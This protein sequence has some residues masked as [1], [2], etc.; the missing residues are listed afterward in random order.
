MRGKGKIM[1]ST[2]LAVLV[3]GLLLLLAGCARMR[4]AP[5]AGDPIIR[6]GILEDQDAIYFEPQSEFSIAAYDEKE[7]F[8]ALEKGLWKVTIQSLNP[9]AA[10]FRILLY[11]SQESKRA[12]EYAQRMRGK[13]LIVMVKSQGEQLQAGSKNLIDHTYYRVILDKEFSSSA[14]ADLF[15]KSKTALQQGRV[16]RDT[17]KAIMGKIALQTPKG[18]TILITQALRITGT[19]I[20]LRDVAVGSGYHWARN[21]TRTYGGEMELRI[22]SKGKLTAINVVPLELYL[23]GVVAGEMAKSFPDEAL[24]AQAII[25]RTL[26]LNTF[27]RFHRDSEF[28]VC[29]DVH[30]QAYIGLIHDS[31]SVEKAVHDTKGL[32]L[33]Y[34]DAL[35]TASYSAVCGGH[36]SDAAEVWDSDGE[37]YLR[38]LLDT[39]RNFGEFDLSKEENAAIWV[40]SEPDVCCNLK[41]AGNPDFGKYAEKYFRWE[42]RVPRAE[43][44]KLIAEQ[45]GTSIGE[46]IDIV[47]LKR[48]TSGRLASINIVGTEESV[49]VRKE[50]NIRRA[51]SKSTLYSACFTIAKEGV[52]NGLAETFVFKGAGWG[53]G[54]GLCQLGAAVRAQKGDT[55]SEILAY[56]YPG[57][58]IKQLY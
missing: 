54:V 27:G 15:I 19:T 10:L 34:N 11:E 4:Y 48:G 17:E 50:L 7:S 46:L 22:S 13:G 38:G 3:A 39:Q 42:Q 28:D 29:D 45:T 36:T 25:S 49:Q 56:Y 20:T 2:R 33:S 8:Q 44:E 31:D 58:Q 18:S 37:P 35:C 26:F 6:V 24:K 57:T 1:K 47:P 23:R 52:K 16:I 21:E 55:V 32:V 9:D 43:L 5:V 40:N 14:E 30:C 12:E 41:A 53:H 51:L